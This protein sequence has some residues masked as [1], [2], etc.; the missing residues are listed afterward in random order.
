MK[1]FFPLIICA[2]TVLVLFLGWKVFGNTILGWYYSSVSGQAVEEGHLEN[3]AKALEERIEL[4]PESISLRQE[5]ADIYVQ[6]ENFSRAEFHLNTAIDYAG[7]K[8]SKFYAKLCSVYVMQDKLMDAVSLLDNPQPLAKTEVDA[9]RPAPP[10][11]SPEPGAY[12]SNVSISIDVPD[13]SKC[14]IKVSTARSNDGSA[15]DIPSAEENLYTEPIAVPEGDSVVRAVIVDGNGVVS[16][17]FL[18]TYRLENVDAVL[19]FKDAT[20]E[21][22][23]REILAYP[24]GDILAHQV[25]TIPVL[26]IE[27]EHKYTTLEDLKYLTSLQEL[28][29][30]GDGAA[31]DISILPTLTTLDTLSLKNFAIDSI[32]F[33]NV[34]NMTWL[35]ELNLSRNFIASLT[36]I[37]ALTGLKKLNL[38]ENSIVDISPMENLTQLTELNL[39]QN[40]I[41]DLPA[42][43]K[44]TNITRLELANN[45]IQL[46]TGLEKLTNL[47]YIDITFNTCLNVEALS[48][49]KKLKNASLSHNALEQLDGLEGSVSL[50]TLNLS[51]N[52]LID[53]SEIGSLQGLKV[54]DI[55]S[56]AVESLEIMVNLV[57]LEKLFASKNEIKS[58][59]SLTE[60]KALNEL[61]IENNSISTIANLKKCTALK[62]VKAF[63]NSLS[64]PPDAFAGT[65]ITV[66]RN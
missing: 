27:G 42:L 62:S 38:S 65:G 8:Q 49:C 33:K 50:E 16:K 44:L 39:S 58:I 22:A 55:S 15:Y 17:W 26:E 4:D 3:A 18:A 5:V 14:Y 6:L 1:K 60:L 25:W 59:D 36:G 21:N 43:A 46:L 24:T 51:N 11:L 30:T 20:I 9:M 57:A 48:K 40:S 35:S 56:N 23:V 61:D 34:A 19:T 47:E 37:D 2:A 13:G 64:D 32:V 53:L 31:C 66:Y 10:V 63:G 52:L 54:L 45:R 29:L 41:Q 12:E 7:A 28:S